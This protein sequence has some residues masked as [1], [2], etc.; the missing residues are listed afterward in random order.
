MK[1]QEAC[2]L[3]LIENSPR[4]VVNN[5]PLYHVGNKDSA[6]L[7]CWETVRKPY[8][9]STMEFNNFLHTMSLLCRWNGFGEHFPINC[10]VPKRYVAK[11]VSNYAFGKQTPGR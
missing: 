1:I 5:L 8:L 6:R 4:A 10:L 9:A 11:E 2:E 3:I 7:C